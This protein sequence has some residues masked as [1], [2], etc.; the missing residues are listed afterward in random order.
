MG[1]NKKK[2]NKIQQVEKCLKDFILLS[3]QLGILYTQPQRLTYRTK[4]E[5]LQRKGTAA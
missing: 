3:K 4:R 2:I 1:P 5:I